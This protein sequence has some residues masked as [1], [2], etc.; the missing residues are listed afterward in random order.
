MRL[1]HNPNPLPLYYGK[2]GEQSDENYEEDDEDDETDPCV[3]ITEQIVQCINDENPI[4]NENPEDRN[5]ND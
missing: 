4:C 1:Y 2:Y 3:H 5:G